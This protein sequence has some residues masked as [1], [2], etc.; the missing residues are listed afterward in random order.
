VCV[1]GRAGKPKTHERT[2]SPRMATPRTTPTPTPSQD[3]VDATVTQAWKGHGRAVTSVA[4]HPKEAVLLTG[5]VDGLVK[6]WQV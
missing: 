1:R 6:V 2:H 5:S 4:Y 3:L